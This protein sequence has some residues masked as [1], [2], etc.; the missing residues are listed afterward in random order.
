MALGVV[1]AIRPDAG[2]ITLA[3]LFG[4]FSIVSGISAIV[5]FGADGADARHCRAS[6]GSTADRTPSRP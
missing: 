2:A 1:L 3:T 4:L 5:P 6:D